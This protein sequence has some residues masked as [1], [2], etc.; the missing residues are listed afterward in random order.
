MQKYAVHWPEGGAASQY[1]V[2]LARK[3]HWLRLGK[4]RPT[5]V[6]QH[7]RGQKLQSL[8]DPNRDGSLFYDTIE[9]AQA[10]FS[11][12]RP[13][14]ISWSGQNVSNNFV[15]IFNELYLFSIYRFCVVSNSGL[16]CEFNAF[17]FVHDSENPKF[18]SLNSREIWGFGSADRCRSKKV[19]QSSEQAPFT[20][21][22]VGSIL[23]AESPSRIRHGRLHY[24]MKLWFCQKIFFIFSY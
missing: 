23:T 7:A 14:V 24:M 4:W 17:F 5:C 8:M 19:A 15:K 12:W 11:K 18:R 20:S 6:M 22:I 13:F 1:S 10:Q 9:A 2:L 3:C 16:S 21:E